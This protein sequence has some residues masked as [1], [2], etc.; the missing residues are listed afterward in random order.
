[1][2]GSW[3][4]VG[5]NLTGT[6]HLGSGQST[7][8]NT[9]FQA[10]DLVVSH[11]EMTFSVASPSEASCTAPIILIPVTGVETGSAGRF[12]SHGLFLASIAFFGLG[13]VLNGYARKQ[14]EVI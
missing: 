9:G 14:E 8:I 11:N 10:G 6:F 4:I 12:G 7:T 3:Y 13:L 5:T 1:M 2:D